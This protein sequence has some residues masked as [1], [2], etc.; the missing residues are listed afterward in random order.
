MVAH[1]QTTSHPPRTPPPPKKQTIRTILPIRN[2]H[3]KSPQ[4]NPSHPSHKKIQNH[5][6]SN[7]NIQPQNRQLRLP[8]QGI[9]I[10]LHIH[11]PAKDH[12]FEELLNW[13]E[14]QTGVKP[15]PVPVTL[16]PTD[17]IQAH[18]LPEPSNI[19]LHCTYHDRNNPQPLRNPKP[20][21]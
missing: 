5:L 20:P 2:S 14:K 18:P 19:L 13:L 6:P 12:E 1:P 11:I 3:Q 8:H 15:R 9:T 17:Q 7:Q 10:M 16:I 4:P 21:R